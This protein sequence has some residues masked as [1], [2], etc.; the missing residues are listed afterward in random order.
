MKVAVI[1]GGHPFDLPTFHQLFRELEGIN[2]YVQHLDDFG[3]SSEEIRDSYGAVVFYTMQIE[4]PEEGTSWFRRDP[5]P[6]IERLFERGQGVVVLHHSFF[7]FPD[8]SFWDSVLGLTHRAADPDAGFEFHL[9]V[10]QTVEV[11]D[12]DHPILRGVK[13]FEIVDEGY[14]MPDEE[15]EGHLILSVNHPQTMTPTAW[16]KTVGSS[17]VLCFQLGHDAQACSHPSFR[18][19][20][21]Q[22]ISWVTNTGA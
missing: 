3:S 5:R 8:W 18:K 4:I 7:A 9:D 14:H 17:R 19:V 1:T 13:A 21:A 10:S 20:L 22:G 6:A 15:I 12:P 16:T 11:A 2:A